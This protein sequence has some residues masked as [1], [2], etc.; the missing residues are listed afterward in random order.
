MALESDRGDSV[1]A[2]IPRP[3]ASITYP[4]GEGRPYAVVTFTSQDHMAY[5]IRV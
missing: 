4:G 3:I 2:R 1:G 5:G